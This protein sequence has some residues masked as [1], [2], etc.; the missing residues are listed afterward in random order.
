MVVI[1]VWVF[2][3]YSVIKALMRP[4]PLGLPRLLAEKSRQ[5]FTL[6]CGETG[7][8]F[9]QLLGCDFY[10]VAFLFVLHFHLPTEPFFISHL[11]SHELR[12]LKLDAK[13]T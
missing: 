13:W 3:G 4:D 11:S 7:R 9:S 10:R 6:L 2:K 12:L 5:H 1:M 8:V